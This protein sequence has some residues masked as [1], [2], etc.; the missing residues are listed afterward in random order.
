MS[1]PQNKAENAFTIK[2]PIKFFRSSID[3]LEKFAVSSD[4]G[5]ESALNQAKRA[6]GVL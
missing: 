4:I 3:D 6:V 2:R 1:L 5:I